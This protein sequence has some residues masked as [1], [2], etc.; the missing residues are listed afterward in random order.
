[1]TTNTTNYKIG[2]TKVVV[3]QNDERGQSRAIHRGIV[4][5]V[6]DNWLRVYNPESVERG[7][8]VN[9]T[10]AQWFA[11]NAPRVRCEIVGENKTPIVLPLDI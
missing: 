8:D 1:M 11:I 9:A 5:G 6:R 3:I 4:I 10:V 7:G 2:L